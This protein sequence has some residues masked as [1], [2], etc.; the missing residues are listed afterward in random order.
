MNFDYL[1]CLC[2]PGNGV[3]TVHAGKNLKNNLHQKLYQAQNDNDVFQSW[4]EKLI[5]PLSDTFL[6]G[7]PSDNGGGIL[8]G[9]NWGPLYLREAFYQKVSSDKIVEM[10]DI[11]VIP[12]LLHD[13]Y[14]NEKTLKET[15]RFLYQDE[16]SLLPVSPLSMAEKVL[17]DHFK[18]FPLSKIIGIGGDHSMSYPLVKTWAIHKKAQN[19]KYAL[20]HFDAHTDLLESRM[21]IDLCFGTWT[22]Q[23]IPYF[24]NASDIIQI[25]IRSSGYD[26]SH[27]EKKFGLKQYWSNEVLKN[28]QLI[29]DEIINQLKIK[30]IEEIYI[31]FDI[32]ALDSYYV[33]STGTPE[34]NGLTPDLSLKYIR[35]LMQEFKVTGFD[36][37]EVAPLTNN[38]LAH[39]QNP[40]PET[41]LMIASDLLKIVVS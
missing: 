40:Q 24:S 10:G 6:I 11:R 5:N 4:R 34:A 21:G 19:K 13:K 29:L 16:N 22:S 3:F 8:R 36:V 23:I 33:S 37:M 38:H 25:G 14:L 1:N 26:K 32:D 17:T 9:A 31:S 27:W 20:I 18:N 15:R 30:K 39:P 28:P 41:T 7:L 2:P 35:S 12:H